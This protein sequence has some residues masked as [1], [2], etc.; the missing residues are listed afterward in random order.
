M[1]KPGKPH[2]WM[3]VQDILE[4]FRD[5]MREEDVPIEGLTLEMLGDVVDATGRRRVT[6]SILKSVGEAY[7]TTLEDIQ[8]LLEQKVAGDVLVLPGH[9]FAASANTY[10]EAMDVAP[11][12]FRHHYVG[13]WKNDRGGEMVREFVSSGVGAGVLDCLFVMYCN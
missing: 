5:K 10:D 1:A 7:N 2:L 4:P 13:T 9:A 8:E 12:L 11:P 3:V 6:R